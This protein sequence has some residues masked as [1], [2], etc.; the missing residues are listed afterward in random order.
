MAGDPD[1]TTARGASDPG[2]PLRRWPL[3]LNRRLWLG[4]ILSVGCLALALIDIDF[5]EMA[6]ALRSANMAWTGAAAASVLVT[7]LGKAWRW[8]LLLYPAAEDAAASSSP[9]IAR[10]SLP[11]LTN[12]W[13]AGAGVNLALPVPRGGDVLRVYWAGE[14]GGLSKS[15]VLGTVAAEK[16]LD[17]VMVAICFLALLVLVAV[18]DELAQRQTSTLGVA[19]LLILLVTVLLWQRERVLALASRVLQRLPFGS[20]MV[21]SLERGL[22]G[23]MGLRQPGRLLGLATLTVA[24]WFFSVLTNYLVFLA[25][26]MPPS[27]VQSLFVLVVL[28]IGVAVPSTPGKIGLFQV[29]CRWA[30]GVFGVSAALGL[31]YGVLL[32]LVAPLL[33]MVLGAL[34]LIVEGWRI[35][36]LPAELDTVFSHAP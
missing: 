13:L 15:T 18:P 19:A 16:L 21:A 25:L 3:L 23:L 30:L 11:R 5:T 2:P 26:D 32:Y 17:I 20:K 4:V 34:A 10:I 14:A 33:L 24:I 7:S 27:W 36:R 6:T 8:R 9:Q 28:Q 29:L 1:A 35:G 31:A 12:I 22:H